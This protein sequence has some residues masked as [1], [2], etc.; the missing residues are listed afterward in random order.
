[1]MA[2]CTVPVS[3]IGKTGP[4]RIRIDLSYDG[5]GFSGWAV[6]PGLR[7]VQGD[8]ERALATVLRLPEVRVVCAGRTDT[9][10]HARGQVAHADVPEGVAVGPLLRRLNGVLGADVRVRRV[11]VRPG[12][13]RRAVLG[14]VAALR[15]PGRRRPV[16]HRPAERAGTCS[17]GR[18][19]STWTR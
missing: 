18:G 13:L 19:R 3:A 16:P 8:L 12:G 9:G 1:M 6:Q 4:V 2:G 5:S 10:V 7:T 11:A 14:A 15:L 17:P